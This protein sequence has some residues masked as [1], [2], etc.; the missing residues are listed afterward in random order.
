MAN[1]KM[2][3]HT[4]RFS[5]QVR[6][7]NLATHCQRNIKVKRVLI[8]LAPNKEQNRCCWLTG[9]PQHTSTSKDTAIRKWPIEKSQPTSGEFPAKCANV[10]SDNAVNITLKLEVLAI[11]WHQR[12]TNIALLRIMRIDGPLWVAILVFLRWRFQPQ[13]ATLMKIK[14]SSS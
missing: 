14:S 2:S 10:T 6:K 1:R 11:F 8:V 7:L 5:C 4:R 3:S 9:G 13:G 12:Q